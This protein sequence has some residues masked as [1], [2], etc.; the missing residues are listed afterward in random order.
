MSLQ[1]KLY[2]SENILKPS[3]LKSFTEARKAASEQIWH[4]MVPG[5]CDTLYRDLSNAN[6]ATLNRPKTY[7]KILTIRP[8][9]P[10]AVLYSNTSYSE[11]EPRENVPLAHG[12]CKALVWEGG[13]AER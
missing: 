2:L 13:F 8:A 3:I 9:A 7:Y 12:L 5:Y 10:Y 1:E 11:A 4:H 6:I